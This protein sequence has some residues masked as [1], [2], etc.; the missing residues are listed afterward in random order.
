[1]TRLVDFVGDRQKIFLLR[2]FGENAGDLLDSCINNEIPIQTKKLN[3]ASVRAPRTLRLPS[4]RRWARGAIKRQS[5]VIKHAIRSRAHH[6]VR[7]C[8]VVAA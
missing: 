6:R 5:G 7:A 8:L 2:V 1:M 4:L 3:L